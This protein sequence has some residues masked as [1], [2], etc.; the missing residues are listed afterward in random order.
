[1]RNWTICDPR[2][3]QTVQF[4]ICD[5]QP[6]VFRNRFRSQMTIYRFRMLLDSLLG[7]M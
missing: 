7:G 6:V 4:R 1:M 5:P 3:L 2:V